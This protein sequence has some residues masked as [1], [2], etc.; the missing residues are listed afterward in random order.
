MHY[1]QYPENIDLLAFHQH[2][3][4][5]F[6]A[7][8]QSVEEEGWDILFA[9]PTD[10]QHFYAQDTTL[11]LAALHE[12]N[13]TSNHSLV[14]DNQPQFPFY[15]GWFVYMGYELLHTLEP[16]VLPRESSSSHPLASLIR[17]PAAILYHRQTNSTWLVA[18]NDLYV[19]EL[20]KMI[21]PLHL[22]PQPLEVLVLKEDPSEHFL[23]GVERC[24]QYIAAGD[25]FQVNLSRAWDA[26]LADYNTAVDV[27]SQL[28]HT[29]PAPFSA[30]VNLG[31][32]QIVSSSPERLVQSQGGEIQMRPIA[33]TTRRGSS[34]AED[35]RLKAQMLESEKERAEHVMLV[36]LVRN[37]L[38]RV[39]QP[40]TVKVDE[41]MQVTTY[42]HVHHIESNVKGHLQEGMTAADI[43]RAVFPGGTITGCPKVRTMQIIRELETRPR[44]AYTGSLGY[45]NQ[46][47]SLD[48]NILIRTFIKQGP[49]LYFRTGAGIVADSIPENE[50][51][52]TRAKAKG[53]LRAL[54]VD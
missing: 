29:N 38:G 18:E 20:Q 25:V 49:H 22:Q 24:K 13:L 12:I 44:F 6:P 43:I 19:K 34:V 30:C 40:G 47:G 28:R 15:G 51:Q 9:F 17:V 31:E 41:L 26:T 3:P 39:C 5:L 50:L 23:K 45:I 48:M 10:T 21:S 1:I 2:D 16:T 8:L 35:T 54:G 27:Y 4:V 42:S 52:E 7:L 32:I 36:D 14:E 33:G 53:L 11:F 37:D 46:D